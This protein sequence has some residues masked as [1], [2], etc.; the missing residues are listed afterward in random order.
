MC[1]ASLFVAEFSPVVGT[2]AVASTPGAIG[3]SNGAWLDAT[4]GAR[5]AAPSRSVSIDSPLERPRTPGEVRQ[6]WVSALAGKVDYVTRVMSAK[7][8]GLALVETSRGPND[9]TDLWWG[10]GN[11]LTLAR[12]GL[13]FD[14]SI[15]LAADGVALVLDHERRTLE[16]IHAD[17]SRRT[18]T[19][20]LPGIVEVARWIQG[21]RFLAALDETNALVV[22]GPKRCY[23]M[24]LDE[25]VRLSDRNVT[26]NI[27]WA[28]PDG[29]PT[30]RRVGT[31]TMCKYGV[32][33]V[34]FPDGKKQFSGDFR[35]SVGDQIALVGKLWERLG[36]VQYR[37]IE[38]PDGTRM[39]MPGAP[40]LVT[41][42]SSTITF[43]DHGE[44][45]QPRKQEVPPELATQV[46]ALRTEGLFDD[47]T[48]DLLEEF[49]EG[50]PDRD[51]V[52]LV[53]AYYERDRRRA[54]RDRFLVHDWRFGQETDDVIA[55]LSAMLGE[56]PLFVQVVNDETGITVRDR[57]GHEEPLDFDGLHDIV[58]FF[59]RAL[60]G[61]T[62]FGDRRFFVLDTRDER[63]AY[64]AL[65]ARAATRL[66]AAGI[67]LAPL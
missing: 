21:G 2:H 52:N 32:T 43:S 4:S 24:R 65:T 63:H 54:A 60:D 67:P 20:A 14:A 66:Q 45:T 27:T 37:E 16:R 22:V 36:A 42:Q 58:A 51:I 40:A 46:A 12:R 17:P 47:M 30:A 50:N 11:E 6:P 62:P 57:S 31:V 44:G 41:Q 15:E 23:W 13:R 48:D 3:F 56:P 9:V 61:G 28:F 7:R 49:L 25:I 29:D 39:P 34:E 33:N 1:A 38:R 18:A 10:R 8:D 59:N 55:E 35:V 53:I 26:W 64:F 19:I 5:I